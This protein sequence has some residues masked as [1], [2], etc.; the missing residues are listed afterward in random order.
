MANRGF[1]L[2]VAEEFGEDFELDRDSDVALGKGVVNFAGDAIT[3]G[4]DGAEFAFST[5][6]AQAERK[7]DECGGKNEEEQ[8]EPDGLVKVGAE[9]E[10]EGRASGVPEAIVVGSLN[11]EGVVAGRN[12]G[13]V[14]GAARARV[15]PL[16]VEA[17]EHVAVADLLRGCEAESG[18]IELKVIVA[19][20]DFERE[21]TE[22]LID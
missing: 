19:C 17:F 20:R 12:A 10:G 8:V 22:R 5:E 1:A 16:M 6:E 4:E 18:V 15:G 14:G 21:I 13:V 3:F 7:E 2:V 11:A 9:L